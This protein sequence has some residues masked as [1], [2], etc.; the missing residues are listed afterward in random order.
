M[1][2]I[3][4]GCAQEV[5]RSC[6]EVAGSK[7][8]ILD[9]GLKITNQGSDYPIG[10]ANHD[11]IDAV[12]ISHAH[13]DH[14]GALPLFDHNGMDCPVFA[15]KTTKALTK[16]ILK[17]AFKIG[18]IA[19][20]HL[21]YDELDITK[22]LEC[23]KNIV[24]NTSGNIDG[25]E[26]GFFDAGHIP[27]S[28]SVLIRMDNT[29]LLYTG[30]INTIGTRLL[31]PAST[32]FPEIDILICESTYGDREH[33]NR[34]KTE[35][36]F[37]DAIEE[38]ISNGGSVIIPSFALG[39]SQELL[40]ILASRK[41]SVPTYFDGMGVQATEIIINNAD[42]LV[43]LG[44]LK[45]AL[46][47]VR[48]VKKDSERMQAM[49]T[50]SIIVTTSGMLT[51]GP[52][53]YYLKYMHADAKHAVFLTGYQ[54]EDTNGHLLLEKKQLFIDGQRKD[55]ACI[56]RQFD[57]S[58]HAGIS[59]LKSLVRKIRPKKVFFVHG[60]EHS[61]RNLSEWASAMGIDSYSPKL[62]ESFEVS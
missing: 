37:L 17:D 27:G 31:H 54:G 36:D 10:V 60:E 4:H 58:A 34:Q 26:F 18:K 62:G 14:T 28:S 2:I 9:C 53:L 61:V 55:V 1:K 16:L 22:V 43:N 41:F 32:D 45:S 39:R 23:M 47:K 46:K 33:T 52:V 57:F 48:V 30:D 7:R 35:E 3:F 6:I 49:K 5:G 12:F 13:L 50:G 51:G 20:H 38:V 19:H 40:L 11:T 44:A 25:I 24:T 15:T 29:S 56:V 8:I 21:G 42:D 59:G